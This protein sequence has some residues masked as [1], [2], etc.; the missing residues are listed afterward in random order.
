[1]EVKEDEFKRK[2]ILKYSKQVQF[3]LNIQLEKEKEKEREK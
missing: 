1:M 2:I 3:T